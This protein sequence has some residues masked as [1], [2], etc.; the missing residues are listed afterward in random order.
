MLE[1]MKKR[2]SIRQF[3]DKPLLQ[4]HVQSMVNAALLSP[5]SRNKKSVQCVVVQNKDM[6]EKLSLCKAQA[7]SFLAQAAAGV[8]ILADTEL[9]DTWVEDASIAAFAVQLQAEHLG[10]GSTWIQMRLRQDKDDADSE[11][12]VRHLLGVEEKYGI[13]CILAVG[14]KGEEK[15]AYTEADVNLAK[16]HYESFKA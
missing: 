5:T 10:L 2:R 11:Q 1:L 14:Y 6:L 16:V 9:A 7:A 15:Q 3:T 8:V 13:L 4:E 12:C